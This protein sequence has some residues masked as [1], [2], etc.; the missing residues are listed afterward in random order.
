M[1]FATSRNQAPRYAQEG[2]PGEERDL[3]LELKL[4]ADVGLLGFPNAGKSTLVSRVSAAKPKIAD[5]PFT[6]LAPNLGMVDHKGHQFVVADIP[7]LVEGAADGKGLGHQFLRHV[8]RCRL[9]LHIVDGA[10]LDE[11]RDPVSDYQT[12][13]TE[14]ERYSAEL[15]ARPELIV[16]NKCDL[17]DA[18]AA[19][20]LLEEHLGHP[21]H[22]ISAATNQ[23]L[24]DLLD[25]TIER[26]DSAEMP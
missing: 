24:G 2:L 25:E 9:L 5:Y 23:G 14:L 13:R 17:P 8:Q 19:A 1:Q 11:T 26:L 3:L 7:G 12:L 15:A 4:L 22:R 10:A 20:D 16:V 6:T 21:V 18:V